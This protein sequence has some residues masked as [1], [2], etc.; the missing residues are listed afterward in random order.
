LYLNFND[1]NYHQREIMQE[2]SKILTKHITSFHKVSRRQKITR[3]TL[4]IVTFLGLGVSSAEAASFT[5]LGFQTGGTNSFAY[6]VSGDGSTVVGYGGSALGNQAFY[7]TSTTG[8]V[9]SGVGSSFAY[10][11][12]QDGSVI[13]GSGSV[14]SPNAMRWTV[15]TGMVED[16]GNFS[17]VGGFSAAYGV[18][19]D[20]LTVVGQNTKQSITGSRFDAMRWSGPAGSVVATSLGFLPGVSS[21]SLFAGANDISADGTVIIGYSRSAVG[22]EGFRWFDDSDPLTLNMSSMGTATSFASA[23]SSDGK[24]A[25][26]GGIGGEAF[27][28]DTDEPYSVISLGGLPWDFNSSRG[29]DVSADGSIV[30]GE[31]ASYTGARRDEAFI[32][33]AVNGLRRLQ[34]VLSAEGINLT[35]WTL[36][37]ANGISDDG[38]T[39]V[40]W[41]INPVGQNEAWVATLDLVDTDG[42]GVPDNDD[43]CPTDATN[44]A[45]ED[46]ICGGM[47]NCPA[48]ANTD[49]ADTDNDGVGDSCNQGIDND[50]DD[51]NNELD[52]CPAIANPTQTDT[53]LDGTGDACDSCPIDATND[54]D[55]DGV[56]GD[57]DNCPVTANSDQADMPDGDGIGN[58]CDLDDDNDTVEDIADN[59]PLTYNDDQNDLDDDGQGDACDD[60]VDGDNVNDSVDACPNTATDAL[61]DDT[62]CALAQLCPCNNDWKNHGAYVKCVA[63]TANDFRNAGLIGDS[64]HGVIVSEAGS[65]SCGAKN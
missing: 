44:D 21:N 41:G 62:G 35:G 42:D 53:D 5:P 31:S 15:S 1:T 28:W 63:H 64:E 26:G 56:C 8:M 57:V 55:G 38:S 16:L 25:V 9:G 29:N 18:S 30:V 49:Q 59:C 32:R 61:V 46:G 47:D 23:V 33:D 12:N 37:A 40:G 19:A 6:D 39:I 24:F 50:G 58:A 3:A 27:L 48:V 34:D 10:G 60:D 17:G 4:A 52:N 22:Q 51:W 43:F 11:V 54:A 36:A 13:V 45:D 65:S 2:K 20:G 7:W 14:S